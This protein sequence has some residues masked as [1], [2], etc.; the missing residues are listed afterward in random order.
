VLEDSFAKTPVDETA[1]EILT[2][3]R[4]DVKKM[5][6]GS[7]L[8]SEIYNCRKWIE[9]LSHSMENPKPVTKI[10]RLKFT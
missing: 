5:P 8:I 4:T 9:I 6:S 3:I 1:R 7:L 2:K 10:S